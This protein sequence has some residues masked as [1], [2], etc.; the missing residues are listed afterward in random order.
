MSLRR[1]A[2]KSDFFYMKVKLMKLRCG[3]VGLATRGCRAS[4]LRA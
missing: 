4:G 3:K 1:R 2:L